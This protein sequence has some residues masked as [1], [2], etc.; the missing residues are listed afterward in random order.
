AW[1]RAAAGLRAVRLLAPMDPAAPEAL[2]A[3]PLLREWFGQRLA[4]TNQDAWRAAHGRLFEHLRDM[5]W[6]GNTPTLEGLGPLYQAIAHGCHAGRHL[7]AIGGGFKNRI[8]RPG[9]D[10][11]I[12]FYSGTKLGAVGSNRAA[13]S[14][15]FEKPYETPVTTLTA[16]DRAWVLSEASS[17]LSAQGRFA[18]ALPALRAGLRIYEEA[19][20]RVTAAAISA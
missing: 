5:T 14:W 8:S 6:E 20:D 16:A 15:F 4:K 7:E 2:D 18:E 3:H 13:I 9:G 1:Q 19:T 11:R 10:G 17:A 12:G